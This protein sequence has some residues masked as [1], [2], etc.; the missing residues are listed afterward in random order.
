M[1][2]NFVFIEVNEDEEKV[3]LGEVDDKASSEGSKRSSIVVILQ[4]GIQSL[5]GSKRNSEATLE[6]I[7]SPNEK[8]LIRSRSASNRA[9]EVPLT[10]SRRSSYIRSRLASRSGSIAESV[11]SEFAEERRSA[12]KR[13]STATNVSEDTIAPITDIEED[14]NP[15]SEPDSKTL[16]LKSEE[17]IRSASIFPDNGKDK[18]TLAPCESSL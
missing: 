15:V 11:K 2:V 5:L 14:T 13:L 4:A 18:Q 1:R 6:S 16:S 17:D 3:G 10:E 8:S 12:S 9:I 7:E